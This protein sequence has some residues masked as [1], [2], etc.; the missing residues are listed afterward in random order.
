MSLHD[1]LLG[2]WSFEN[3]LQDHAPSK[4]HSAATNVA[5]G[6]IP[7][8]QGRA[9][10]AVFDGR[11]SV[12][13]VADHPSLHL[14]GNPFSLALWLHTDAG[15]GDVV[16][17][18]VSCYNPDTRTGF[19]LSVASMNGV[20]SSPLVNDRHL[21]FGIDSGRADEGWLDC[22]RPGQAVFVPALH[23]HEGDLYAG[24]FEIEAEQTGHL[25][26]YEADGRW[27][28]LGGCPDGSSI[29]PAITHFS[30]DLYCSTGRYR[31][32][33]SALGP[34]RN[35]RPGGRV[36]R[37][38]SDEQWVD[39]GLVGA[40]GARPDDA[41]EVDHYTDKA[42]ETTMLVP[43]RGELL[44][45][46]AHRRGV[47]R[48]EGDGCWKPIGPEA[49]LISVTVFHGRLYG[50]INGGPV[51]RY[52]GEGDWA[53]CGRP[54][55]S[56]QT[57]GAAIY[58]SELYVGTWPEGEVYRYDG[59]SEW[60]PLPRLEFE[61]EVMCLVVYN[62]KLY[63]G[64]LPMGHVYRLDGENFTFVGNLDD[65]E[66][67]LR[68]VWTMA[69]Y[70]GRLF[71]GTLPS[72]RVR[73]FQAGAMATSDRSLASGWRHIAAVRHRNKLELFVDGSLA[74]STPC[75]DDFDLSCDR[76]L[77]IGQGQHAALSGALS[78][79]RLYGRA[80]SAE[81]IAELAARG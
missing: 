18:L 27:Q 45:V 76:P 41:P 63:A 81:Q 40:E 19:T 29:V 34:R 2:H 52:D 62:G 56:T 13:E 6:N 3:D 51:M 74:A 1:D 59:G 7:G 12:I 22:G 17:D 42:D 16:G 72:G 69:I 48:Y 32:E 77:R 61:R 23:V 55:T 58:Q 38:I 10:G 4:L 47:W 31:T 8:E 26:R 68:R 9:G 24:T 35:M 78:D 43:F 21:H 20:T 49:R 28:D 64:A 37:I 60:H 30:G 5:I 66:A 53:D 44:A 39:C 15:E 57:Y 65:S 36:Y 50:T 54:A 70:R 79:L 46:S 25:W 80:L 67:V 33:G 14:A 75:D 11:T 73:H 71:G